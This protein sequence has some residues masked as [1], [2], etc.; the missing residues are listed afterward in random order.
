MFL[1]K[2]ILVGHSILDTL[3]ISKLATL[4]EGDQKA[5]FSIATTPRCRRGRYSFPELLHFALDTYLI[6]LSVKQG[7]IGTILKVFGMTRPGIE[8]LTSTLSTR[9]MNW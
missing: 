9:K 7:G 8:P 3:Y 4:V 1:A 6:L 2:P 5:P